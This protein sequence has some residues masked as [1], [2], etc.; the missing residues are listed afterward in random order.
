MAYSPLELAT[1]QVIDQLERQKRTSSFFN[2]PV[3]WARY[4][5]GVDLWSKQREIANSL[6]N[7]KNV[8]VKA[9]HGVGKSFLVAVLA[10]WWV[11]TRFPNAIVASTA[12][13]TQQ[14]GAIVW[15][16]I[17]KMYRTIEGRYEAG[18]IDHKLPGTINADTKDN[19]WSL[20]NGES[21]GFGKKPPDGKE[22]DMLQG[23]HSA[24]VLALGD[25]AC[26][27]SED[28]I[29]ALGSITSN[30]GSRRILI[31]NPTNPSS[32]FGKIFKEDKGWTLH[33][34]SVLDSPNFTDEK[35]E[36][37]ELALKALSGPSYVEDKK[38]EYG[39]NS[40]R[41]KARVLGEFAFDVANSLITPED[42]AKAVD[43]ELIPSV[44]SRPVLGVDV[45]RYGPD[46]TV[47]YMNHHNVLRL[48]DSWGKTS[49]TETAMKVHRIAIDEAVSEVRIDSS[50]VGGGVV[51]ELI[52]LS[53]GRYTIYSMLGQSA[54]PDKK[55]WHNARAFWFD[56]MRELMRAEFLD[57]DPLDERLQDELCSL[58]YLFSAQSGGLL[59]ESKD[60]M[61]KRGL[62][63]PD[64]ADAASYAMADLSLISGEPAMEPGERFTVDPNDIAP[65]ASWSQLF[66]W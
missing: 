54:S 26:G 11:D 66:P 27:L 17:R 37:S 19:K 38:K 31:A 42:I 15:N 63:S 40:A 10:C 49:T 46:E 55:Q 44:N 36:M 43:T 6:V 12:P 25:E 41:Y 64:F 30:E 1:E 7:N 22:G 2:D 29:E 24:Y 20:S 50:G 52:R 65:E 3:L 33:T 59:I 4:M 23:I 8:A 57:I 53:E 60:D 14:I 58:E 51:D 35:Y 56:K 62:K 39:E 28:I 32:Y 9:G 45:A 47:V 48:K 34:I 18:E 61:R 21:L 5:L 16:E 13:S